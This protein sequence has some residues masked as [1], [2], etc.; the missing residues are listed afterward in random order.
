MGRAGETQATT[1]PEVCQPPSGP[2]QGELLKNRAAVNAAPAQERRSA[3][4]TLTGLPGDLC[5]GHVA[6]KPLG[7]GHRVR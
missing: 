5:A 4:R 6:S 3:P 1:S 7:Q 2:A